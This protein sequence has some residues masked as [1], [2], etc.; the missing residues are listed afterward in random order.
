MKHQNYIEHQ[1]EILDKLILLEKQNAALLGACRKA[2]MLVDDLMCY[3]EE[4]P[5]PIVTKIPVVGQ[6]IVKAIAQAEGE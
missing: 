1:I 2:L 4:I 3:V 6:E 5:T